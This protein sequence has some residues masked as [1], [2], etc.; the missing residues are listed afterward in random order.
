MPEP[1]QLFPLDMEQQL[2]KKLF[3]RIALTVSKLDYV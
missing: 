3:L 1:C 2:S